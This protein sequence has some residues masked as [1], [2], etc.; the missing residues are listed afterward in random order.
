MAPRP[1]RSK[2]AVDLDEPATTGTGLTGRVVSIRRTEAKAQLP[3]ETSGPALVVT[4]ELLNS[5]RRTADLTAVVVN[6]L[7]SDKAPATQLAAAPTKPLPG[8][9]AGRERARGVYVFRV[10]EDKRRPVTVTV[11][12]DDAPV[13]V[14]TGNA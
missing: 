12:I 9:V 10:P 4:V 5:S 14:F 2:K 3:G 1:E 6:V 11:S 8:Q 7:D 13:L